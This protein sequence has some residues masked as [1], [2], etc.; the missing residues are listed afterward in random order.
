MFK[1]ILPKIHIEIE[2]WKFNKKYNV[3]VS[4]LGNFKDKTKESIKLMVQKGGYLMV[5]LCN[6]KK[7]IT[8][9]IPAHR[10][11]METWCPRADIW[12]DKLTVDHLDHNKRNNKTTNL[13]WVSREE[14]QQRAIDDMMNDDKDAIIQGLKDKIRNLEDRLDNKI[15]NETITISMIGLKDFHSWGTLKSWLIANVNPAYSNVKMESIRKGVLKAAKGKTKYMG[16]HWKVS[17]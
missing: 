3:Y 5:P 8:K 10:I 14:N 6:N 11:V 1:I 9:Y 17:Q 13:E 7:G 15:K 12:Q 16:Y 4:N 2:K